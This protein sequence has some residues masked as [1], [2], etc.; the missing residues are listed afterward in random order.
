MPDGKFLDQYLPYL[1]RRAD[2]ALSARFY[3][4]LN[5]RGIARSEWRVLAVLFEHRSLSIRELTE[6]SLS[7]Q[8]TVTHAVTRLEARGLVVRCK[9]TDDR[10]QRFVSTTPDGDDL[11]SS[12]F[13]EAR[14]LEEAVLV[15]AGVDDPHGLLA[16]LSRLIDNLERTEKLDTTPGKTPATAHETVDS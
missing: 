2:Q 16:E 1:L 6:R 8:P 4:E 5:T 14:R 10:R 7:P 11:A 3:E 12:L 13:V 15:N 9:G